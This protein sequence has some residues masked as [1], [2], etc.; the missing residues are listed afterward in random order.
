MA[1]APEP[2]DRLQGTVDM[3]I[4]KTLTLGPRHGWAISHHI[5]LTSREVLQLN[6]GALYPAL[7]R[8]E[9]RGWVTAEWGVS[10][11][12]R[13]ARFYTLTAEGR[14]QLATE[15]AGWLEYVRAVQSV[16]QLAPI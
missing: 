6:Q 7:H 11:S 9:E 13:R 5:R 12:N 4:L 10:E 1:R 14:A 2:T 15:T 16:M 3:L 8:L